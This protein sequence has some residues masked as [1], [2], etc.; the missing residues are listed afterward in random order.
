M[1]GGGDRLGLAGLQS[2]LPPHD[3][4]QLREL[5]PVPDHLG[6]EIGLRQPGGAN[7]RVVRVRSDGPGD[8]PR[9][10]LQSLG[11]LVE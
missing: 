1:D 7:G 4:L 2:V 3:A 11:L 6:H 8:I 10:C 9:E 5:L